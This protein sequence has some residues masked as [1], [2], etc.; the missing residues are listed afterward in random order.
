MPPLSLRVKRKEVT[1]FL[2]ADPGD[3]FAKLKARCAE[4]LVL[5][6]GAAAIQ[7]F[8]APGVGEK[9]PAEYPDAA[10]VS[11]FDLADGSVIFLT[12]AGEAIDGKLAA[13]FADGKL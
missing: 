8:V 10:M 5:K 6:G 7:L 1:L 2:V 13:A 12:M 9:G 4:A 11:D 3:S